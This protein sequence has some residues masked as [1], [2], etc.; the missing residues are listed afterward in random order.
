MGRLIMRSSRFILAVAAAGLALTVLATACTPAITPTAIPTQAPAVPTKAAAAPTAAPAVAPTAAPTSVPTARPTTAAQPRTLRVLTHGS[1]AA[2]K[3]LIQDFEKANN[4]TLQFVQGG[5]A[6]ETLNKAILAIGNP[7][8]DVIYGV[9]NTFLSRAINADIL[10]P[11]ASPALADIPADL[12]LDASNRLLPVDV[13]YVNLNYDKKYFQDKKLP[14]PQ[15]LE[16]LVNPIYQSLLVVEN[17]AASSPGLAFL[18][19]T[20]SAFGET[21]AYTWETYWQDL[22]KNDVLVV[23]GWNEA[24][25]DEFS[26]T[27]K[28]KRPL[29]VSYATSPAAEL[30]FAADP[31]PSEPPTGNILPAKGSFRQVEFV[32][33]L[34]G[35]KE[36]EL[37]RKFVDFMLGKA[38]Q[39]DVPLQM[40]VYPANATASIPDVFTKFAQVPSAPAVLDPKTIDEKRDTWIQ[41]WTQIVL[42]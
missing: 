32:G 34:K 7:L 8:A 20:V 21:G 13:G 40:F 16:D 15:R 3:S 4:V 28:G 35:A 1:F 26:A 24:Y 42:K 14:V 29:V 23:N 11:Y 22:R 39:E 41:R 18:M 31:K 10:D 27:G 25:Y 5:D 30:V 6:G 38:F 12:K 17:P 33:I 2:T 19:T 37:A 9:D 36:P